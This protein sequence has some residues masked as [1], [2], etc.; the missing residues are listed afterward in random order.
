MNEIEM[1][2]PQRYARMEDFLSDCEM[3]SMSKRPHFP[4]DDAIL[5]YGM[6]GASLK[7]MYQKDGGKIIP[8]CDSSP[9]MKK[10]FRKMR[11]KHN[12][13]IPK[14][15]KINREEMEAILERIVKINP[16]ILYN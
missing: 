11:R 1:R 12:R 13:K 4:R 8:Q 3:I 9:F 14:Y 2:I 10:Y 16:D 6:M 15:I 5:L 7:E